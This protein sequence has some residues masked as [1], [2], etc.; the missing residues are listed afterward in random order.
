MTATESLLQTRLTAAADNTADKDLAGL[1]RWAALHIGEQA[2]ALTEAQT[3]AE[4]EMNERLRLESA[5]HT[6]AGMMH[7]ALGT[8]EGAARPYIGFDR[9]HTPHINL[10]ATAHHDPD[11]G[12][13]EKPQKH[14][15]VRGVAPRKTKKETK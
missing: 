15:D 1:L 6:A 10:M 14:I 12:T 13:P 11:Y 2:E 7:S 8:L 3:E 4:D 9:D 5:I